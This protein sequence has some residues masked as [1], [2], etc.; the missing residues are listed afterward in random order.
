MRPVTT[1]VAIKIFMGSLIC[2][3]LK[4]VNAQKWRQGFAGCIDA[5]T[6]DGSLLW[7]T[8]LVRTLAVIGIATNVSA[9]PS[10]NG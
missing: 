6:T 2:P 1:T 10:Y 7:L 3:N 5:L 8:H 4:A 9:T